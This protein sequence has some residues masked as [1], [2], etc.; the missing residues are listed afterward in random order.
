MPRC[1]SS[2]WWIGCKRARLKLLLSL[3][4]VGRIDGVDR[5]VFHG[6]DLFAPEFDWRTVALPETWKAGTWH[7]VELAGEG[8]LSP[9]D[10]YYQVLGAHFESPRMSS[11]FLVDGEEISGD[12][13]PDAGPQEGLALILPGSAGELPEGNWLPPVRIRAVDQSVK[14][15]LEVWSIAIRH[16]AERPVFGWGFYTFGYFF[17]SLSRGS[18]LFFHYANAHSVYVQV[19]HDAGLLGLLAF[20]A[21]GMVLVLGTVKRFRMACDPEFLALSIVLGGVFVNAFMHFVLSDQRYYAL[22]AIFAGFFLSKHAPEESN[23]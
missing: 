13:S 5:R 6:V 16:A 12:L 4:A 23:V 17:P 20:L 7:E 22:I 21:M 18:G 15:R 11:T 1:G 8:D 3:P 2:L 9:I 10:S 14:G 19:L